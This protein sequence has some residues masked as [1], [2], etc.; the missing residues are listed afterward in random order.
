M[1]LKVIHRLRAF[2]NAI[3][4]TFVQHFTR[5]QLTVCSHGSSALAELLV[6][7]NYYYHSWWIKMIEVYFLFSWHTFYIHS[8][9]CISF[10]CWFIQRCIYRLFLW[11]TLCSFSY[12]RSGLYALSHENATFS[13]QLTLQ[14]LYKFSVESCD[15]TEKLTKNALFKWVIFHML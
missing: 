3:R 4:R 13:L 12:R 10:V 5:I 15:C 8:L 14:R 1:T 9:A 7:L 11:S 6:V 2:S